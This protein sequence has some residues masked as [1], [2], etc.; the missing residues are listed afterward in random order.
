MI[1]ATGVILAGG[2]SRRFGKNK[3]LIDIHGRSLIS[4]IVDEF[5]AEFED[6]II[7]TNEPDLYQDMGVTCVKDI[8]PDSGSLSGIFSSLKHSRHEYIVTVACDMPFV[9]MD[10]VRYMWERAEGSDIVIPR[11]KGFVEPLHAIY[12]RTCLGV[13]EKNIREQE[14]RIVKIFPSLKVL[15]VEEEEIKRMDPRARS[16][17]NINTREDYDKVMEIVGEG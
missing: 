11:H 1:K 6:V 7:S 4:I 16:F 12:S 14:L 9:N 3:A 17:M 13:M 10:L 2:H 15:Y 5:R 8:Y